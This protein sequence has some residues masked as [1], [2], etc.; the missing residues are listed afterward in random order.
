M[1]RL[2]RAVYDQLLGV[3]MVAAGVAAA[4]PPAGLVILGAGFVWWWRYVY[5]VEDE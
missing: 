3:L 4:Y 1:S 5:Q 2:T